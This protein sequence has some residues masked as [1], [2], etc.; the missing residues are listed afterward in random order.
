MPALPVPA[1]ILTAPPL[2]TPEPLP[3]LT[4]PPMALDELPELKERSPPTPEDDCPADTTTAPP[5]TFPEVAAVPTV[6]YTFPVL[7]DDAAPDPM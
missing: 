1:P 3:I 4:A 5:A 2:L 6:T 7:P